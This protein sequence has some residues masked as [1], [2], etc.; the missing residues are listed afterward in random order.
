MDSQSIN[1]EQSSLYIFL[2]SP[3]PSPTSGAPVTFSPV[4]GPFPLSG[5]SPKTTAA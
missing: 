1:M 2:H 4:W 3:A 5:T